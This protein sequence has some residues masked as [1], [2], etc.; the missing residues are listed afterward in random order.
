MSLLVLE[1]AL[2]RFGSQEIFRDLSLSI[3]A[4]EKLGLIGRNGGGK[5]TLLRVLT[6]EEDL[7]G[8]ARRLARGV[9]VGVV[10]Q[11][12][13]FEGGT[14]VL[15]S[16]MEGLSE[17]HRI[18]ARMREVEQHLG[19]PG[20]DTDALLEELGDLQHRFE[21]LGGYDFEHR[22]E[23]VLHGFGFEPGDYQKDA[24][25]L[26]GGERTRLAMARVLVQGHDLLLLDEPTNHMDLLGV[27]WLEQFLKESPAAVVVIS[28]DRRFLD[29]MC[30]GI[31]EL[32]RGTLRRFKGNYSAFEKQRDLRYETEL[33]EYEKQKDFID[34]EM[35][36]IRKNMGSQRTAEAKGRL[37]RLERLERIERPQA[38]VKAPRIKLGGQGRA[39]DLVLEVR[40]LSARVGQGPTERVLFE[41]VRLDV[42]HGEKIGIVGPNGAGKSTLLK[43]LLGKLPAETGRVHWGNRARPGYYDQDL[44]GIPDGRSILKEVHAQR[45]D[46]SEHDIRSHLARFLFVDTEVDKMVAVLSGGERARAALAKITLEPFT[47]LIMDEP[48][49]HLD[50]AA[51]ASLESALKEYPGALLLVSHDRYFLDELVTRILYVD[52]PA[53]R[54]YMGNYS[55]F[56]AQRGSALAAGEE[57]VKAPTAKIQRATEAPP[58]KSNAPANAEKAKAPTEKERAAAPKV[59]EPKAGE[60]KASDPKAKAPKSGAKAGGEKVRNPFQFQKLEQRIFEL[61]T[62][63]GELETQ[64]ADEQIWRDA[65]RFKQVMQ[66][67]EA[68]DAEL[69]PLYEKWENWS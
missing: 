5:T 8:G 37:K 54:E 15:G 30:E 19:D 59:A 28:H 48:T 22:V 49:N 3:E 56:E 62:E 61:E 4:G 9:R 35:A 66:R 64:L 44:S 52:G 51:R 17:I 11:R 47:C 58:P 29:R 43:I 60:P 50:I 65:P 63:R 40:E 23:A 18:E 42:L 41:N 68:V 67:K 21:F 16:V 69:V 55:D 31:L 32:S 14:T 2:K 34:R 7:D 38:Q 45:Q 53:T 12:P 46:L 39:G 6:G 27:E 24:N 57:R 26:S 1:N 33:R 25:S 36:F 10:D 20:A 13:V